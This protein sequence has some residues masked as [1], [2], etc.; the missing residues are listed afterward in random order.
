[1]N[2][3]SREN[4]IKTKRKYR[5]MRKTFKLL[6]LLPMTLFLSQV[7]MAQCASWEN[8]EQKEEAENAHVVYRTSFKAKK[9][10]QAYESWKTAYTIAPAADGKRTSH[11]MDGIEIYKHFLK[12]ETDEA[13][14]K[15]Y[16]AEIVKL[17]DEAAACVKEGGVSLK[18]G[19]GEECIN[20][21]VGQILGRKGFDMYYTL[22]SVYSENLAVLDEA[23]KYGGTKSEYSVLMPYAAIAVYQYQKEL[24][25]AEKARQIHALIQEIGEAG[26]SDP[27]YGSYYLDALKNANASFKAIERDIFDCA[28]FKAKWE[29]GYREDPSPQLA[30]DLYNQLKLQG[31][32]DSDALMAELKK[33]YEAW[34]S[35]V[36]AQR[37]AEFEANNP[38]L[39]ANKAYKAG[40]YQEAIDKYKEALGGESDATKKAGYHN[41]IAS[42]LFRKMKKYG[43]ARKEA[44]K[45]IS[46]R[47]GWGKPVMMIGDM[48]ATSA[49]SC[50]DSWNQRLAVLAAIDKYRQAS[51]DAEFSAEASK[52]ISKYSRSLP[53]KA[54]GHMR[55]VKAGS[56]Q[57]VGCWIGE[58]VKVRFK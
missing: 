5:T 40:N 55:S 2:G 26:Q 17:Y 44:R 32:D 27:T 3:L 20:N 58:K 52:K 10:D 42:I 51:S 19:T 11:F 49:S 45:A 7:G 13:K 29:P 24:I 41:S 14:K 6:A 47:P 33:S 28:Y 46:L 38:A 12:S 43:E 39:L 53:D 22:N 23:V 54:E 56:M 36:N 4:M 18:C 25:D 8:S 15:E 35:G 34:A 48:Y 50:G 1:M 16:K 21:K 9:F 37:K 30:K 57:T 31:C